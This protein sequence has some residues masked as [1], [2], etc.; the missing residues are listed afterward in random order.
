MNVPGELVAYILHM[1]AAAIVFLV[2][3]DAALS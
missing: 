2:K 3:V 1:A